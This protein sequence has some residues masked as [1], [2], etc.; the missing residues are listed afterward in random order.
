MKTTKVIGTAGCGKTSYLIEQ[1][2]K[3]CSKYHPYKIG[4]VSF[5][6]A[7][8]VELRDRIVEKAGVSPASIQNVRTVHSMCFRLGEFKKEDVADRNLKE[9]FALYPEMAWTPR[10]MKYEEDGQ[11]LELPENEA[12]Y[13]RACYNEM[14]ILRN[15]RT[16]P[17]EWPPDVR[18]FYDVWNG[19]M[20]QNDYI[21]FTGMLEYV[22]DAGLFPDIDVLF[23]DEV[24][25]SS[26]LQFS[27]LQKWAENTEHTIYVGDPNQAI[28]G[29]AGS[30]PDAFETMEADN[31]INLDQTH[32]VPRAIT[33]YAKKIIP[34]L[35]MLPTEEEGEVSRGL[36]P[37]LDKE[38]SHMILCRCNYQLTRWKKWLIRQ[39]ITWH[40]PYRAS[41][42]SLNPLFA[43]AFKALNAYNKLKDYKDITVKELKTL[44]DCTIAK[45][46]LR[47]GAKAGFKKLGM[48][49]V[50][51]VSA[52][53]LSLVGFT[54]EFLSFKKPIEELFKF[55]GMAGEL[56]SK[57]LQDRK[58]I[59]GTVHSVKGGEADHVHLDMSTSR[60]CFLGMRNDHEREKEE[61]RIAFVA[62]TRARKSLELL[63]Q[64][65]VYNKVLPKV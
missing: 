55:P 30:N 4:A 59:L 37:D 35:D 47:K 50:K 48:E 32:R 17:N 13:N 26:L 1:I 36:K 44:I 31:E 7:A 27:L 42:K 40:N 64:K 62:V 28:Y 3:A 51:A 19:W 33:E 21:D 16:P 61:R 10:K 15:K 54:D 8:T 45:G 6:K 12:A 46:N 22:L 60:K 52:G 2:E 63:Q 29:W 43:K 65:G 9:F 41:D 58:I 14:N 49:D 38:G 34:D 56:A 39:G 25:D 53:D 57:R 23:V 20:A 5:S 24:Q 11:G 18:T